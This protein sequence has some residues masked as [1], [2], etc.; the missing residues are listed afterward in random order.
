MK[1]QKQNPAGCAG[2]GKQSKD[3]I[4]EEKGSVYPP[5]AFWDEITRMRCEGKGEGGRVW[6]V[7]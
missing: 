5:I 7:G 1:L 3:N 4:G 2:E 6:V